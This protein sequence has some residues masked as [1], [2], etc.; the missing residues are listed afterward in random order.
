MK[1]KL[2]IVAGVAAGIA[3]FVVNV[4]IGK[5]VKGGVPVILDT[6]WDK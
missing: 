3:V 1:D 4:L 5:K 6:D 2:Y